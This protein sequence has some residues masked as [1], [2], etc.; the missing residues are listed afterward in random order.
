MR[1]VPVSLY[2][3]PPRQGSGPRAQPYRSSWKMTAEE[4][5]ALGTVGIVPNSTEIR[6]VPDTEEERRH[7]MTNYQS[8]GH[9]SV[10]PPKERS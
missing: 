9:D 1:Q 8:A 4:A 2:F 10:Q 6:S 5:A 3:L 7:S